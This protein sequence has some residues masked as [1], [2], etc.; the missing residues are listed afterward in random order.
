MTPLG[1]EYGCKYTLTGPDGT[2]AVFNDSTDPN[3]VGILSPESSGLDSPEVREDAQDNTE[4]DG[5][6]HGNF[7]YG[8]RP[9]ILQGTIIASSASQR[10]ER[11]DK[12]QRAS[13]AMRADA[14][15]KWKPAGAA[16]E[17]ELKLR[18][19]QPVRITKGYVKDF[20]VPMVSAE[21]YI[22]SVASK[23]VVLPALSSQA[24]SPTIGENYSAIGS[25]AW[26]SPSNVVSSNNVYASVALAGSS[27]QES[28][29]LWARAHG[30]TIPATS[31]ITGIQTKFE[32]KV[33]SGNVTDGTVKFFD[34]TLES[35]NQAL[36]AWPAADAY[37]QYGGSQITGGLSALLTPAI[38]NSSSFGWI[39]SGKKS[40]GELRTL[41]ID[42]MEM[43]VYYGV[44]TTVTNLG[45]AAAYPTIKFTPVTTAAYPTFKNVTT[46][47]SLRLNV[48]VGA[49]KAIEINFK[50][51]T[52][53]QDGVNI[54]QY[55]E[56]PASQWWGLAPGANE[57]VSTVPGAEV[58]FNHT[59]L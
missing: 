24:K 29:G 3:F 55:L 59:Y 46:G 19:Q 18:R 33:A 27:G 38:V 31:L 6:I 51:K 13:N 53:T 47:E 21:A 50:N 30:F 5:G 39:V 56:F 43:T 25:Q 11:V 4:D 52:I 1:V 12:L 58:V 57:V 10:N 17:V 16:E 44:A 40:V 15:L 22:R 36:W 8:R 32:R 49:G 48:E 28:N 45:N 7:F 9:V 54:Y 42:H 41:E 37:Q 23:S 20:M 26:T 34:G 2:I 35:S 14:T